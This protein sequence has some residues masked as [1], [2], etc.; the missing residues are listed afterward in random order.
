MSPTVSICAF[1]L[2]EAA[3]CA[4]PACPHGASDPLA[5]GVERLAPRTP[6]RPSLAGAA[7]TRVPIAPSRAVPHIGTRPSLTRRPDEL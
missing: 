5:F 6:T 4:H 1:C 2:D 7:P 3:P